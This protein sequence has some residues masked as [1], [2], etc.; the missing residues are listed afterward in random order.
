MKRVLPWLVSTVSVLCTAAPASAKVESDFPLKLF[1]Q[2]AKQHPKSNM[3]VS[4]SSAATC[5]TMA[6][7]GADGGTRDQMGKVLGFAHDATDNQIFDEQKPLLDSLKSPGQGVQLEIANALFGNKNIKFKAD[8][9]KGIKSGF[10][11]EVKSIEFGTPAALTTINGWVADATRAKIATIVSKTEPDDALCLVNAVYFNGKWT[12][13]FKKLETKPGVFTL[14]DAS[15]KPASMMSVNKAFD[16]V[17]GE[18]FQAVALP[19]G[20]GR[21]RM[22][23]FLPIKSKPLAQFEA[24]LTGA[25]WQEWTSQMSERN[26]SVTMP[27]FKIQGSIDLKDNLSKMGMPV[28]FQKGNANFT[29]MADEEDIFISKVLHKTYMDVTEE[30]TEAAAVTAVM[31]PRGGGMVKQKPFSMTLDRPFMVAIKDSKTD[32]ILFMGHVA[33]PT[34]EK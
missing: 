6:W 34:A 10:D 21:L 30:G 5:L 9:L 33:D 25:K 20:D 11:G 29:G 18:D 13:K 24:E 23:V 27:K 19:Y 14:A 16:Y 8:F 31:M 2:V 32:A 26:G 17:E 4:P 12:H 7:S 28:A 1:Q 3:L 15:T 22:L